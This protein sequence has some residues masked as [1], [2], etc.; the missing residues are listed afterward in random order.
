LE[1]VAAVGC[2][3]AARQRRAAGRMH[4]TG[5]LEARG[6]RQFDLAPVALRLARREAHAEARLVEAAP[7]PVDPAE[8]ERLVERLLVGEPGARAGLGEAHEQLARAVV[9]LRQP[10]AEGGGG[11]EGAR[12]HALHRSAGRAA[13]VCRR[14]MQIRLELF[15]LRPWRTSDAPALVPLAN[16]RNV[17]R[18]LRD[19]FPHPYGAADAESWVARHVG[20]EP[21]RF[22]AI[23]HR[24]ELAGSITVIPLDD[25]G[26]RSAEIGY[27]V[28][29]PFW[30]RGI[31]TDAVRGISA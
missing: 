9:V 21:V 24:G 17:W 18:N 28:G 26:R 12:A 13:L 22:F 23:E 14:S 2:L 20:V 5:G 25:V 31:A 27:F 19:L 30:G 7:H 6:M 11:G 8:A 29:E 16:N 3:L 4:A 10:L 1:G 15:T